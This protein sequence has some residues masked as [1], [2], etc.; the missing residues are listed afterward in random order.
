METPNDPTPQLRRKW[1]P[2]E[3]IAIHGRT[4][5]RLDALCVLGRRSRTATVEILIEEYMKGKPSLRAAVDERSR[6]PRPIQLK[7]RV[8]GV[9]PDEPLSAPETNAGAPDQEAPAGGT[10]HE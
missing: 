6:D 2:H 1:R 4:K 7:R 9:Y 5:W 8:A 3:T 10:D